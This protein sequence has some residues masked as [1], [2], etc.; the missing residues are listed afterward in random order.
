MRA[1]S[2]DTQP[3][4]NGTATARRNQ[5]GAFG[6]TGAAGTDAQGRPTASR[7]PPR[8]YA[9]THEV[10]SLLRAVRAATV[11][12]RDRAPGVHERP[13]AGPPRRRARLPRRLGGRTP[14][15]R[16]VLALLRA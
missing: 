14:L 3:S 8:S 15:P 16:G 13:G 10:R 4:S 7:R 2:T 5:F 1:P 6:C 9:R 12:A 11:G